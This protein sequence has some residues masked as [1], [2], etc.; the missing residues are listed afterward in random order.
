[1][2]LSRPELVPLAPYGCRDCAFVESCGGLPG[3]QSMFGCFGTCRTCT[4][5][6]DYTCPRKR[7]FWRDWAEVGGISPKPRRKLPMLDLQLPEYVPVIRH[8]S[9]RLTALP[10]D[11]AALNTF[12]VIDLRCRTRMASPEDVRER[13]RIA[14]DSQI[15]LISVKEDPF[16]E[17]FWE[18][19]DAAKLAALARLGVAAMS[20][21]NFSFFD[22]APRLH[23]VRNF[24]RIVRSAEDIADAGIVPILHVNALSQADWGMWAEILRQNESVRHVCK[25]F[26]TGLFDTQRAAEAIAGLRWLQD[27][28][29]RP[30]HP[31]VV[32]GR[33]VAHLL[34]RYFDAI[35]IV[36]SVPFFATVKRKRIVVDGTSVTQR[37]NPTEP[38]E[39]LDLLLSDN[40]CAYRKLVTKCIRAEQVELP[41][42]I[43]DE[44]ED[45]DDDDDEV[46]S[47]RVA[48]PDSSPT[49]KSS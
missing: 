22:D 36:D 2:P 39:L 7:T 9:N 28:V 30:L 46:T 4:S 33:R 26:Q 11:V 23:N 38:D 43:D 34:S 24:W 25:E 1:M 12:E 32:G 37:D 13:F 6:C 14:Q 3:Q 27:T 5:A 31:I 48:L 20:T 15:L 42:S 21:P 10:L 45:D 41:D 35:T 40:V 29:G 18:H 17:S 47:I 49:F 8:G 19:R 44:D 16:I